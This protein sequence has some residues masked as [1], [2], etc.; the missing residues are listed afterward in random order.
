MLKG[1]KY[2]IYPTEDQKKLI[3]QTFG[4]VRF[5][6]NFMLMESKAAHARGESFC[7]RNKFNYRLTALKQEYVWLNDVDATSLTSAND[8]LAS[9]FVKFFHRK[10]GHPALKSKKS[11]R[12]SYTS[13]CVNN[14]IKLKDKAIHLP[15]VGD[16]KAVIHRPIPADGK[17][18]TAT[19]SMTPDQKYYCSVLVEYEHLVEAKPS[20]ENNAVGL[21]YKSDGFYASSEGKTL[22]SPKY[23]RRNQRALTKAQRSL[24]HK[25]KGSGNW[26][27][28]VLR[29]AKVHQR[30]ANE[31]MN[32]LHQESASIAKKYDLVC[33]E[34]LN[35]RSM[36]DKGFGNGK[37]TLDNGWGM[38]TDFLE[39]KLKD[40]GK[41][42]I[43]IDR[44]YPSSQLCSKCGYQNP[45]LK[46]LRIRKWICPC[47]GGQHDRD[48]NAAVNIR[49]E[50]IRQY[51]AG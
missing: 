16:L 32:F 42:L 34:D 17:I 19:V 38:F 26:K 51:L 2:R 35:M 30:I 43:R 14:N 18:K 31:R 23:Y 47:C 28:A 21:D 40:Q 22:G 12:K 13:K 25:T 8:N 11:S 46:D 44:W 24:R 33:I 41:Q 10:A 39:Y 36:A 50:G 15:K 7:S 45:E 1:F 5:V 37:A 29:V 4:C 6:Y 3:H 49:N 27:K 9:G 48:I 20:P